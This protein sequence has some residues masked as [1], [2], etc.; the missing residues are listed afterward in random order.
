M[1]INMDD[2]YQSVI[3]EWNAWLTVRNNLQLISEYTQKQ[4]LEEADLVAA[5]AAVEKTCR[6]NITL[7]REMATAMIRERYNA[8]INEMPEKVNVKVVTKNGK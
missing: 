7:C 5:I 6:D 4:Q 8:M 3:N 2:T 1:R